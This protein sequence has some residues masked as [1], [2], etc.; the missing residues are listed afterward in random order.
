MF[1]FLGLWII[2][3][4]IALLLWGGFFSAVVFG[5]IAAFIHGLMVR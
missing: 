2:Y 1:T 3:G 5:F 4:I